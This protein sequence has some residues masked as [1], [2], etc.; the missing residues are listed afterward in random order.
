MA[1]PNQQR[2]IDLDCGIT[3]ARIAAWLDDE[4]ALPF[5]DE[6]WT[7]ESEAQRCRISLEPLENRSFGTISLERSHLVA[8][9]DP[10]A[11]SSFEKLFTLR[12]ISAGG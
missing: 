1:G 9:G 10:D 12:F 7:Y 6:H 2:I 11:L 5:D 3:Y 4:L 8:S